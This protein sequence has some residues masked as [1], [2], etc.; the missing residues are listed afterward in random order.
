MIVIRATCCWEKPV[1]LLEWLQHTPCGHLK[2]ID[3]TCSE[4]E[5]E[6]K[7]AGENNMKPASLD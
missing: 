3:S 4:Y 2:L 5:R 6:N 7:T 1:I